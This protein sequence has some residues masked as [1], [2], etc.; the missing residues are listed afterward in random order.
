MGKT[1]G[2]LI[3]IPC[4][5]TLLVA[6]F[7]WSAF[8]AAPLL[9]VEN[10]RGAGL[11]ISAAIEQLA[12]ADASLRSLA[13]YSTPD[14]A[15]YALIDRRGIIRFHTN[16]ALIGH[17]FAVDGPKPFPDGISEQRERLGTGEEVYLL[18]TKVHAGHDEYHLVLALH[19]YRADQVIRRAK[20]GVTVVCAL[21]AALWGLTAVV[22]FLVRREERHRREMQ[23][24]EELARLGEMG[25]IMAHEIRNPLASIKGFAQLVESA[26]GLEQARIYAD[27]IV[28]QSQR[29][30]ALV[31][32]LLAFVRQ[33]REERQVTDLET[34]VRNCVAMIRMEAEPALVEVV[35]APGAALEVLAVADRIDQLLLNLLK[36]GV[37]AMPD[38]G[39]L[40]VELEK[41]ASRAIIR[42]SD[43]GIGIP[44]EDLPHIFEPFWTNKARGTGLGLA[45]CRKVAQ[46][47]GGS[48]SVESLAGYGTT[49]TLAL[50]LAA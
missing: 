6:W 41:T 50:P 30:E 48:L 1:T 26:D 33:D 31:D 3:G 18:R 25:A 16:P 11:S 47:H 7:A 4:C 9:A 40:R 28:M 43:R 46:E 24:R 49:F 45:L 23:R 13:R 36:N 38:G 29:M 35:Y 14:I 37:Q 12:V 8:Q 32:D 19:T 21:T 22:L 10:L 20:T 17:R 5:F 42:V 15:Y 2:L 44:P 27:R 34:H 39:I